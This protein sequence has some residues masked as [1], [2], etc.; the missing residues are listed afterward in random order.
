MGARHPTRA[1]VDLDAIAHNAGVLARAAAPAWLAAV[2]KGR[3]YG[4]GAVE[5][6]RA[7]LDGGATWI[8]VAHPAEA[9]ELRA[10]GIDAPLL[11]LSE[12]RPA[13]MAEVVAHDL[14]VALYT[15]P[16]VQAAAAAARA[17]GA[18]LPV[19]LKVDTGMHRAG[20]DPDEVV[21]LARSVADDPHLHLEA[22]WSHCAVADEPDDPFTAEQG[23]QL[24]AALAALAA[25]G[26]EPELVHLANSAA[27]VAHP[28]AR[29]DLVRC[30]I[31][32]YGV[33]PAPGLA[34]HPVVAQL[35]PALRLV[36]EVAQV[37]RVRAG[38]RI[39]YGLRHRFDEDATVATVPIGYAD[40]VPR[41]LG[42]LRAE[43]LVGG[44]RRR[45]AGVVTMDQLMVEVTGTPVTI[46]DEVVLLGSQGDDAIAPDEWA[47]ALGTISYE[48][49]AG[50]R[51]R[52]PRVHQG[53][54]RPA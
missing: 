34:H 2:V 51:S 52:V 17:A 14:R 43:V 10:A 45:L 25:E 9:T 31:A 39:S 7:A 18:R 46:G 22:V 53:G 30:G 20:C 19:H 21:R 12:P 28:A 8:A 38:D 36:A 27:T 4:H 23:R 3:G 13:A 29:R 37:R 5:A 41:R 49:V 42:E 50:V 6:A 16:G 1:E 26:I 44:Q 40:G 54:G 33:P 15:E 48:V 32:I 11:V 35:R 24:D 47:A